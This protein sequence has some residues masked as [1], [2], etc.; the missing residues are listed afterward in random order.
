MMGGATLRSS[1]YTP[2]HP[3]VRR[4]KFGVRRQDGAFSM[5][6]GWSALGEAQ[7]A[8]MFKA[9]TRRRTPKGDLFFVIPH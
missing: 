4:N 5:P 9:A 8:R 7:F 6:A 3:P 2:A 1:N